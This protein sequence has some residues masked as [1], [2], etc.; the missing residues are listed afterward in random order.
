MGGQVVISTMYVS[1]SNCFSPKPWFTQINSVLIICFMLL[2]S[3][4]SP[5]QHKILVLMTGHQSLTIITQDNEKP[6]DVHGGIHKSD[7]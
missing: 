5:Q 7:T 6:M 3:L 4:S 1:D 2:R